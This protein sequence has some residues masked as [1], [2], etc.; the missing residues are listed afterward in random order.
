MKLALSEAPAGMG[1]AGCEL[2]EA[3]FRVSPRIA[4]DDCPFDP[5]TDESSQ[6]SFAILPLTFVA[7]TDI[8]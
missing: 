8:Q 6:M 7:F 3:I 4:R 2:D 5:T 1:L